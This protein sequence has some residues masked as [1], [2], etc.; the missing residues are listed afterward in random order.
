MV[1][2]SVMT[3]G[4]SAVLPL[5][6]DDSPSEPRF[7]QGAAPS[8]SSLGGLLDRSDLGYALLCAIA[9][10]ACSLGLWLLWHGN[11]PL[12]DTYFGG[13]PERVWANLQ[14]TQT[15]FHRTPF[16]PLFAS[17]CAVV[18]AL[19]N[20]TSL[21]S[22][23]IL[24]AGELLYGFL[25]GGLTYAAARLWGASKGWAIGAVALVC[26]SG[27][28]MSWGAILESHPWGGI[29]CLLCLIGGRLLPPA[30]PRRIFV[31]AIL[32]VVAASMVFTNILV[33]A[34][35][36]CITSPDDKFSI[37]GVWAIIRRNILPFVLS[38]I[39]GLMLL[40]L[41]SLAQRAY[42]HPNTTLG[43]FLKFDHDNKYILKGGLKDKFQGFFAYGLF[44]PSEVRPLYVAELAGI[45]AALAFVILALRKAAAHA[46]VLLLY[47]AGIL[48]FHSIYDRAEAF[49]AAANYIVTLAILLALAGQRLLD[50]QILRYGAVALVIALG[51]FNLADHIRLVHATLPADLFSARVRGPTPNEPNTP[52]P[53]SQLF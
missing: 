41:A 11:Q 24:T 44:A 42:F 14:S 45:C 47:L 8:P 19:L 31:S 5:R 21:S 48:C 2:W 22:Y 27:A 7:P 53:P 13:D 36:T 25:L 23:A 29:S 26:A 38:L 39:L 3:S 30:G 37:R 49:I 52:R 28:F 51:L 32:F 46:W 16:H 50:R 43:E 18:A 6:R 4:N 15:D 34:F 40:Y 1:L 9:V 12:D 35:A 20:H 33:W 17:F 10:A